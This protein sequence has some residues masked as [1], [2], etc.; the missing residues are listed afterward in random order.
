MSLVGL[1]PAHSSLPGHL[2]S[3][4]GSLLSLDSLMLAP[5]DTQSLSSFNSATTPEVSFKLV[6]RG[7]S[8]S[9]QHGLASLNRETSKC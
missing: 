9:K 8:G 4:L 5:Y 7:L 3:S 2:T 6:V 1:S